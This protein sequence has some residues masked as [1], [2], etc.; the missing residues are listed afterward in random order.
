MYNLLKNYV[1]RLKK[2]DIVN[3]AIK[4]SIK[5]AYFERRKQRR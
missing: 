1:D 4:P 5:G 3:F 2:E